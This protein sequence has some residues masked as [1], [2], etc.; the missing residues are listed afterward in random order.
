MK[1][2]KDRYYQLN[3][4]TNV[5]CEYDVA[6]NQRWC[7][8]VQP[9]SLGMYVGFKQLIIYSKTSIQAVNLMRQEIKWTIPL[10]NIYKLHINYPVILTFSKDSELTGY[11]FFT[12]YQL[13]KKSTQYSNLFESDVDVW[14]V[15][16]RGIQKIDV[17]S[18]DVLSEVGFNGEVES[19]YGN[20]VFLYVQLGGELFHYNLLNQAMH[21]VGNQF[22]VLDQSSDMLLIGSPVQQQL[23]TFSNRII[24][25]NVQETL[26][27]VHT[28]T[29]ALF[30]YIRGDQLTFIDK[31]GGVSYQF[32]QTENK[33]NII[34]R[35][36]L[37][38]K[39]RV[40]Y[41][42]GQDVWILKHLNKKQ[43]DQ[44]T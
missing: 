36:K 24:S 9:S 19:I 14:M 38:N 1:G 26:F 30:A 32:T 2:Y 33:G 15:N 43:Y 34:Y 44:D 37:N 3:T 16:D 11:D 22:N 18:S 27:K 23:R 40:F 4:E 8:S 10:T 5:V 13:W 41:N 20:D 12:G 17:I 25:E 29:K 28:P 7:V 35:Y 21:Q 39:V 6:F 31:K 42:D